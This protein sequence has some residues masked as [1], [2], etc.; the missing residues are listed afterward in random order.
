LF[1]RLRQAGFSV[2]ETI[3]RSTV[4]PVPELQWLLKPVL[5]GGGQGISF[6]EEKA[7]PGNRFMLQQYVPGKPCSASFVSNGCESVLLGITEQLI[8]LRPFGV[9]G[10][11][12]CGNILPFPALLEKATGEKI[13]EQVR[14]MADFI[15]G[16]FSLAGVNGFD[17]ILRN[18]QVWLTEVNPRYSASME[19]IERAYG[20]SVFDLHVQSVLN[21]R[22]PTFRLESQLNKAKFFGKS[23]LFC[24]R[25][26]TA[27][28]TL[29]WAARDIKDIPVPGERLPNGSPI[30]TI[31]ASRPTYD[32]TLGEMIVRAEMLKE[33][34][35]E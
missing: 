2:P 33:Q 9:Q 34:I 1:S 35:Y 16:E 10:F 27:R 30:C 29:D 24:E 6:T 21:R 31:L 26:S 12:Y 32:E 20:L 23:I 22:L 15:A 11:R 7:V 18:D 4:K 28:E 14:R 25:E 3:L 19:L 8:G 5:S 17:F 13:V